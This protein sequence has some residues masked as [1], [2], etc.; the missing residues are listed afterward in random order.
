[1]SL[2][3]WANFVSW[4]GSTA[5]FD[6]RGDRAMSLE[7]AVA[8]LLKSVGSSLAT[9][10]ANKA[11]GWA[12]EEAKRRTSDE[13]KRPKNLHSLPFYI[14][15]SIHTSVSL[16]LGEISERRPGLLGDLVELFRSPSF[17]TL[18]R[19][20]VA[21]FIVNG[22]RAPAAHVGHSFDLA[23]DLVP[24]LGPE[25]DR[26]ELYEV[27]LESSRSCLERLFPDQSAR[28]RF[29]S[30]AVPELLSDQLD[31]LVRLIDHESTRVDMTKVRGFA[32]DIARTLQAD[33][34]MMLVPHW[35]KASRVDIDSVYVRPTHP[36]LRTKSGG[37]EM[38]IRTVVLGDPGGGKSSL[39]QFLVNHINR[40]EDG[41]EVRLGSSIPTLIFP[42]VLR[43]FQGAAADS[44]TEFI[45]FRCRQLETPAPEGAIETLLLAGTAAVVFDGLDELLDVARRETVVRMV[46]AFGRRYP[47]APIVVTSRVVGYSDFELDDRTFEAMRLPAFEPEDVEDYVEAWFRADKDD[48]VPA[49]FS[50]AE[51]F[52]RTS[53]SISDLRSNPL[54]LALLC[55]LYRQTNYQDLPRTRASIYEKCA[56]H[57]YDRWD[58]NR[59]IGD[60]NFERDFLP[61]VSYFASKIFGDPDREEG[62]AEPVLVEWGTAFAAHKY[63]KK[64]DA[65]AF[66]RDLVGHCTGRLWVLTDVG[67]DVKGNSLYRFTHRTF[68][69]YFAALHLVRNHASPAALVGAVPTE[70]MS[71]GSIVADLTFEIQASRLDD[72]AE[73]YL[74][75]LL[76]LADSDLASRASKLAFAARCV[77]NVPVAEPLTKKIVVAV[78]LDV[79][80]GKELRSEDLSQM[81]HAIGQNSVF[82]A[83]AIRSYLTKGGGSFSDTSFGRGPVWE[84]ARKEKNHLAR[85]DPDGALWWLH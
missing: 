65:R 46:E 85:Q 76:R 81:I 74:E 67:L 71:S 20:L 52:L 17:V 56:L 24:S 44:F 7:A 31:A 10:G 75:A 83:R 43:D 60:T 39:A 49:G 23:V 4:G 50:P 37:I 12:K 9:S 13:K 61:T 36:W 47:N 42:I 29:R 66:S 16:R 22:S 63:V 38:P 51:A 18:Q 11:T 53:H 64:S 28:E 55:N 45:E 62:V 59:N 30:A 27:I 82:V 79:D 69:E 35:E 57:L 3:V 25:L 8:T 78:C 72:A 70:W 40:V 26:A 68:L 1:M 34:Q 32:R 80:N 33:S 15:E 19:Q 48:A 5:K 21:D 54:M 77:S 73:H 6:E 2:G 14:D 58:R 41:V 84:I